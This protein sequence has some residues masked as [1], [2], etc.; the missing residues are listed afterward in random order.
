M[1]ER[2]VCHNEWEKYTVSGAMVFIM[3]PDGRVLT[4]QETEDKTS[5]GRFA[6]EY[7][8]ICETSDKHESPN[9]TLIR[10][11]SEE[12]GIRPGSLGDYIDFSTRIM[13]GSTFIDGV[14][15]TVGKFVC[16]DPEKLI[17]AIG[18][19]GKTDGVAIIGWKTK[20]EFKALELREG[21]KNIMDK[22][23]DLIFNNEKP[24]FN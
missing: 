22:F 2:P 11:I 19:N 5:T 6:V 9:V 14:W 8:V 21:V 20:E 18:S 15:A 10:G 13:W 24:N 23:G 1:A 7:G 12:L 17:R 3:D 4:L 16:K